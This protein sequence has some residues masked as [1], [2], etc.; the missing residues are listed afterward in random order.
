MPVK[1]CY[2]DYNATTPLL[3]SVKEAMISALDIFGNPSSVHTEGRAAKAAM[4]HAR[5][6]VAQLLNT[7]AD[8]VMFTSGA[9]EAAQF[10]LTKHYQMGRADLTVSHLYYGATEHPCVSRGGQFCEKKRTVIPVNENGLIDLE[11]LKKRLSAHDKTTGVPLVAIQAANHETGIIQPTEDIAALT[12]AAGGLLLVDLVQ[13]IGKKPF[14]VTKQVGD[15]FIISAHKIGGPKGVGAFITNGSLIMPKP[16]IRAGG[17]EKG[18]R[19]GTEALPLIIGF[20][21]AAEITAQNKDESSRLHALQTRLEAEIKRIAPGAII[22]GE[23][24]PRLPNTSFFAIPGLK[25][26]M[27]QI[28]F[29][30]NGFAVSAGAACSSG[31]VGTSTVLKA[32]GVENDDGAIRVS[33]GLTT[34]DSDI[35][36]FLVELKNIVMRCKKT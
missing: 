34:Q 1:R 16:L 10:A 13:Y 5:R 36:R 9:S 27:M 30:L 12:R 19:G 26:E 22:Y 32:M 4:Q 28:A 29:D 25:A 31:K 21:E 11:I 33:T 2:L 6:Q 17:Q 23:G 3:P 14:D 24:S 35:E 8:H 20:G 18:M 7:N 15:F